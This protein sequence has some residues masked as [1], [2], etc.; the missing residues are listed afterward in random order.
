MTIDAIKFKG[1]LGGELGGL[2]LCPWQSKSR[3]FLKNQSHIPRPETLG[4][5]TKALDTGCN[6]AQGRAW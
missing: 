5:A 2:L 3:G 4:K 6:Q 1:G